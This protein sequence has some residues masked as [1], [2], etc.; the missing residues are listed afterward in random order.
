[1]ELADFMAA[2][3]VLSVGKIGIATLGLAP[4]GIGRT[5]ISWS[6]PAIKPVDKVILGRGKIRTAT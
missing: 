2:M 3:V 4:G 5:G 6:R 1:M